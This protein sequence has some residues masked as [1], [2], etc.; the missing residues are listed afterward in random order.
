MS[1]FKHVRESPVDV[2]KSLEDPQTAMESPVDP[3]TVK[4]S[5]KVTVTM[6]IIKIEAQGYPGTGKTSLLNL[7][8][9]EDPAST[10]DSTDFVEPPSRYMV[11]E[12]SGGKWE[13]LTTDKILEGISTEMK[14]VNKFQDMEASMEYEQSIVEDETTPPTV[15]TLRLQLLTGTNFSKF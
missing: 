12:T 3:E 4:E 8:M 7:A 14:R 5:I 9:G 2:R 10:R 15:S 11:S 1:A 13:K 6:R